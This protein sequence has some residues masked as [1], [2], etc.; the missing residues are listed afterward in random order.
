MLITK[1]L[2]G[3]RE[4]LEHPAFLYWIFSSGAIARHPKTSM[5][6]ILQRQWLSMQT[7]RGFRT[8]LF[9]I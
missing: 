1:G 9:I 7:V 2:L 5:A 3:G 6:Q 8:E 4:K